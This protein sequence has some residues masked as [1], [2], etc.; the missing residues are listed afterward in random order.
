MAAERLGGAHWNMAPGS[1]PDQRPRIRGQFCGIPGEVAASAFPSCSLDAVLY[2][3]HCV[4][5]SCEVLCSF[6]A[7]V[8]RLVGYSWVR[9]LPHLRIGYRMRG[10]MVAFMRALR[11]DAMDYDIYICRD[12]TST[13]SA[14]TPTHEQS[15]LAPRPASAPLTTSPAVECYLC[16]PLA[17]HLNSSTSRYEKA[18]ISLAKTS[19]CG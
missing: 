8:S 3:D 6:V 12:T 18:N 17:Q 1:V 14:L 19:T 11:T 9:W 2:I 16:H 15:T 13:R 7:T 4:L 5:K 10:G